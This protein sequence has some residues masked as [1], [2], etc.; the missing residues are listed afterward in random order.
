MDGSLNHFEVI[1]SINKEIDLAV[2]K[3]LVR[4]PKWLAG[5]ID[6]KAIVTKHKLPITLQL[7]EEKQSKIVRTKMED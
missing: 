2:I 3:T 7:F 5:K 1:K 4:S 6:G